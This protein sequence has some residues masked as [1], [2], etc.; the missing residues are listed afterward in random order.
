MT[1]ISLSKG[2]LR[3]LN[4]NAKYME[5]NCSRLFFPTKN[6]VT[7]E[8]KSITLK[9][10]EKFIFQIVSIHYSDKNHV[11]VAELFDGLSTLQVL[12]DQKYWFL[13]DSYLRYLDFKNQ[14]H[15]RDSNSIIGLERKKIK[16][17]DV[18]IIEEFSIE[19]VNISF[20]LA[21]NFIKIK[22]LQ[23]IPSNRNLNEYLMYK[24]EI[25]NRKNK[26]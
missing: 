15:K 22:S 17:G 11:V 9:Q 24:I 14:S 19:K 21:L 3:T 8:N 6:Y 10:N 4:D 1:K 26:K 25:N 18:L 5:E 20:R 23:I 16:T 7:F 2:S 13:V 12:I